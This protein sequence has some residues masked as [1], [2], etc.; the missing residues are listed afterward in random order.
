MT[1]TGTN[2][3]TGATVTFGSTAAT[4]VVVVNSTTIT[5]TTP[6][7]SAGAV[8]VTV[9]NVGAQSGS[10]ASGF[11]YMVTPDGE[12][13]EPEQ[14]SGGRRDGGDDHGDELRHGSDGDVWQHGGDQ[15]GGGEQHDDHGD[16]TG[17]HG[18]CGDGDG[19]SSGGQSGSL[20]NGFTYIGQPTVSS[21][22]PNNGPTAGGTAVTITGTNFATGATVTFGGTAATSVVVVNS[23]TITAHYTS[24]ECWVR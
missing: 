3:A 19:D 6:A 12:Q 5:A 18:G 16:H 14:R 20:A 2:F 17:G 15:C 11:T 21:V 4:S 13:C 10:L 7:G 1:I 24:R 22:S 9:T 23:T 8:T